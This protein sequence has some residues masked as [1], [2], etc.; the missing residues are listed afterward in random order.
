MN[1]GEQPFNY[2]YEGSVPTGENKNSTV[3]TIS[4]VLG[5]CSIVLCCCCAGVACGI[6]AVVLAAVDRGEKGKFSA[7]ATAGLV[8]GIIGIVFGVT[9]TAFSFLFSEVLKDIAAN[10]SYFNFNIQ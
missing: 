1:N 2:E 9:I 7:F 3:A 5:I 6:V 4:M 8:C 10:P